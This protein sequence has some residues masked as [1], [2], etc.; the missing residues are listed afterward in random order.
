MSSVYLNCPDCLVDVGSSAP[1]STVGSVILHGGVNFELMEKM[2]SPF[3]KAIARWRL[4]RL[5]PGILA[6]NHAAQGLTHD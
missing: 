1:N 4:R 6:A 3:A 5:K 2:K